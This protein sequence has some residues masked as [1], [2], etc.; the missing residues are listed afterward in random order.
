MGAGEG[1][2]PFAPILGKHSL[3]TSSS[4]SHDAISASLWL[5]YSGPIDNSVITLAFNASR[6]I[7]VPT[8][9]LSR[10]PCCRA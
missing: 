7:Q 6:Q 4:L 5:T 1:I 3:L 10:G 9:S 8:C 2:Y